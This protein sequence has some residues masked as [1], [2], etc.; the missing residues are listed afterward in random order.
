MIWRYSTDTRD[1]GWNWVRRDGPWI[2]GWV[3]SQG[4]A[5]G[6]LHAGD[7]TPC[8]RFGGI[9]GNVLLAFSPGGR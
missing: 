7:E 3:D 4:P 5:A 2:V 1:W 9:P 8:S 6:K